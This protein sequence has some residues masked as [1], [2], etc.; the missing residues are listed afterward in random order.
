M[1]RKAKKHREVIILTLLRCREKHSTV[2]DTTFVS[3][4]EE[5]DERLFNWVTYNTSHLLHPLLS[6]TAQ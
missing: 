5:V 2:Y 4:Y 3:L 6:T 1:K